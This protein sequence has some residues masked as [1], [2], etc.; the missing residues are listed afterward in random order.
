MW[1]DVFLLEFNDFEAGLTFHGSTGFTQVEIAVD[2]AAAGAYSVIKVL[3][4]RVLLSVI[5]IY[6]V[7]YRSLRTGA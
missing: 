5:I 4:N 6:L 1:N 3:H 7:L 2:F